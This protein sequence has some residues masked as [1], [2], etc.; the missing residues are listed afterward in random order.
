MPQ[1]FSHDHLM[2]RVSMTWAASN[3]S[4]RIIASPHF[5]MPQCGNDFDPVM[6]CSECG[7]PITAKD[8]HIHP[9]PGA[10]FAQ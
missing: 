1:A 7:E 9:D 6:I 4:L 2:V 10:G 3:S 5:E 8:V